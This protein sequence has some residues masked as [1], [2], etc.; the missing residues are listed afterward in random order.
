LFTAS[1]GGAV[2]VR[3]FGGTETTLNGFPIPPQV[4]MFLDTVL[5][6]RIE[7]FKGSAAAIRGSTTSSSAGVGGGV[8]IVTKEP[9][10]DSLYRTRALLEGGESDKERYR[11]E[12][13]YNIP[14][15]ERVHFRLNMAPVGERPFYLPSRFDT[16]RG[17]CLSP[18]LKLLLFS[19]FEIK[20]D[21]IYQTQREASNWGIPPYIK[22][23]PKICDYDTYHGNEDTYTDYVGHIRQARLKWKLSDVLT[24]NA[25]AWYLYANTISD[26][27]GTCFGVPKGYT[28]VAY[29]EKL[30]ATGTSPFSKVYFDGIYRRAGYNFYSLIRHK[31]AQIENSIVLGLDFLR[32]ESDSVSSVSTTT[33]WY[34]VNEP[35]PTTVTFPSAPRTRS[36]TIIEKE[37][38]FLEDYLAWRSFRFLVGGRSDE[39]KSINGITGVK[40]A[41]YG[42]ISSRFGIAYLINSNLTT[43]G[44]ML[45]TRGPNLGLVDH[46]GKEITEEWK[47]EMLEL[48]VKTHLTKN[49]L[50]TVA[51]FT[52][53]Q[54]NLPERDPTLPNVAELTGKEKSEGFEL[55]SSGKITQNWRLNV[56]YTY[57]R[58]RGDDKNEVTQNVPKHDVAIQT[59]YRIPTTN[60]KVGVGL[61][62]VS[63]RWMTYRGEYISDDYKLSP[64]WVTDLFFEYSFEDWG[65]SSLVGEGVNPIRLQMKVNNVFNERYF[66]GARHVTKSS[67]GEPFSVTVSLVVE[68]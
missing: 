21:Y 48:G 59:V 56:S 44:V 57:L 19:G 31:S 46:Q 11:L 67:P 49:L 24:F 7:Y 9:L 52:I 35:L 1:G 15:G 36:E 25:G 40:Y 68:F 45:D 50:C 61:K 23:K 22:G 64:Y 62:G 41:K 65:M 12:M 5:I 58:K 8:N 66:T 27:I 33:A 28:T 32:S 51:G 17:Y 60:L 6:E 39:H 26:I 53:R 2:L 14:L 34:D 54:N 29:L 16:D 20:L 42:V 38:F 55:T 30:Y 10:K 4:A 37:G 18:S 13:D 3:G 47:A 63:E 43:Y